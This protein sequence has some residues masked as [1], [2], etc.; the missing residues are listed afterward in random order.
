M[1][2]KRKINPSETFNKGKHKEPKYCL[3]CGKQLEKNQTKYCCTNCQLDY[4]YKTWIN[5]WKNG[6]VSGVKGYDQTSSYIRRYLFEKYN[7]KC[8]KCGWGEKNP[9]SNTVPLELHHIDGD[10]FNN[11]EENLE[12]LCPNCHSLTPNYRGLHSKT[13]RQTPKY[14]GGENCIDLSKYIN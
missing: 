4:Q 13:T 11:K 6:N 2:V 12:L 14:E 8:Q 3:N 1:P 7:C 5:D 10:P 9:V